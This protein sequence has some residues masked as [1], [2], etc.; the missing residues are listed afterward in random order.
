MSEQQSSVTGSISRPRT[1]L[2]IAGSDSG[3]GAGIQAD[4]K[5]FNELKVFGATAITCIT[6]QNPDGVLDVQAVDPRMVELQ[7][8]AVC[9]YFPVA[10]VKTGMLYSVPVVLAVVKS[11]EK[12]GIP[13][14]VVDPVMVATSGARLLSEDAV[15]V[16]CAK[17]LPMARVITPNVP[18]LEILSNSK[19]RT[20]DDMRAAAQKVGEK[21]KVAVAAKGGH[22]DEDSGLGREI[23]G[24]GGGCIVDVLWMDGELIEFSGVRVDVDSTH[25]TGCSFS[26]ALAASLAYGRTLQESVQIAKGYVARYISS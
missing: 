26:A 1:V 16:L 25:G 22:L 24:Q 11:I 5:A 13:N 21:Y 6:A 23:G 12:A 9:D 14:L 2:T 7:V 19:V 17:L 18:E 4:L 10:A 3:G 15:E 20:L 8:Q